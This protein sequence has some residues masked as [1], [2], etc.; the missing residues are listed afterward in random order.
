MV[1]ESIVLSGAVE[2]ASL[3]MANVE[4]LRRLRGE[5]REP[6]IVTGSGSVGCCTFLFRL[7]LRGLDIHQYIRL[8]VHLCI[9]PG[10]H[11]D[12]GRMVRMKHY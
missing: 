11:L 10:I 8:D 9:H 1:L 3:G 7:A 4:E 6:C 2:E 5:F 12:P